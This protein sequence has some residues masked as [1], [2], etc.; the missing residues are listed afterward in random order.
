MASRA[1][2]VKNAMIN[3]LKER[4]ARVTRADEATCHAVSASNAVAAAE[5]QVADSCRCVPWN[6]RSSL[7]A[8]ILSYPPAPVLQLALARCRELELRLCS[9]AA[10]QQRAVQAAAQL[11]RSEEQAAG[12]ARLEAERLAAADAQREVAAELERQR[13]VTASTRQALT[14]A[15]EQ[16]AAVKGQVAALQ[17]QISEARNAHSQATATLAQLD[18]DFAELRQENEEVWGC[19]CSP[20]CILPLADVNMLCSAA[21]FAGHP[22]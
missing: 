9:A 3:D 11:A 10:E 15:R 2:A 21:A 7:Q 6:H 14:A 13:K 22:A 4:L 20:T 8:C 17:A 18:P 5:T 1:L 19:A 16:R 12:R